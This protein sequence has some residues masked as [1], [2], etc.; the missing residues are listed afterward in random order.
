[1]RLNIMGECVLELYWLG[2]REVGEGEERERE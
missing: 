1:V 2:H